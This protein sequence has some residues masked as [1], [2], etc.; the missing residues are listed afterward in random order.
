[1]QLIFEWDVNKARR[2]LTK[3][4]VSFEEAKTT[5]NDPFLLTFPDEF[6][7]ET[8]DRF[9]SIGYSGRQRLLLVVH[10][11]QAQDNELLIRIISSRHAT[12]AER[13]TYEASA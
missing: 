4:G 3:H 1:M 2:N 11:E 5:F 10:T 13:M 6:H 7:S 8:E 9:V 12:A